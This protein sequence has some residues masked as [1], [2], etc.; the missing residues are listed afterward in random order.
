MSQMSPSE[1]IRS[2]TDLERNTC[3][4]FAKLLA[5]AELDI[6][7]GRTLSCSEIFQR[8]QACQ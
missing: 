8:V 5:P 4:I 7:S 3:D 1:G 2:V 6:E